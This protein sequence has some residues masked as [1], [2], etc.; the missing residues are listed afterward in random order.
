MKKL[1]SKVA[2]FMAHVVRNFQYCQPAQN[3][4]KYHILFNKK[5]LTV[6]LMYNDFVYNSSGKLTNEDLHD[7]VSEQDR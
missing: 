4:P 6:G 2:Y 3:Q 7:T 5:L 1:P